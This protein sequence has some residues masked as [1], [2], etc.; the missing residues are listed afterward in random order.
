MPVAR[1][2]RGYLLV[3]A[4][5]AL[6]LLGLIA[7]SAGL[8]LSSA[9]RALVERERR[10]VAA[11][12]ER[13]TVELLER[14]LVLGDGVVLRGDT[15]VEFDQ[16]IGTGVLCA[17]ESR[18]LYLPL[19]TGDAGSLTQWLQRPVADDVIAVHH[20]APDLWWYATV[21]SVQDRVSTEPCAATGGWRAPGAAALRLTVW[22]ELPADLPVGGAV[23]LLRRGRFTLYHA[24]SGDW[25]LG[26]RRC[27]PWLELCGTVQPVAG[28]LRAPAARGL[29]F[30][31]A[32]SPLRL[33][34]LATAVD[35]SGARGTV[36]W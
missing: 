4:V 28:P 12:T 13:E 34:I 26:W 8:L 31:A 10:D 17:T 1:R 9:R 22:E 24:G 6:V 32:E 27:H 30:Q 21:D 5:C 19:P 18:A 3:E 7:A 15:A 23:R 33:E 2:R 16:L 20:E 35:G 11:R 36:Y 14:A 29:R 25:M